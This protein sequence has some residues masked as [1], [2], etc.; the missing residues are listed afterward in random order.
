MSRRFCS[1][2]VPIIPSEFYTTNRKTLVNER[3]QKF[4][5]AHQSSPRVVNEKNAASL[6]QAA[7]LVPLV[8]VNK[9]PG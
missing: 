8:S 5:K 1:Y 9:I 2:N 4:A 3:V 7:V 6:N